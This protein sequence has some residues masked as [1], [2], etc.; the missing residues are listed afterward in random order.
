M[1][2]ESN[3]EL[4]FNSGMTEQKTAFITGQIENF[5]RNGDCTEFGANYLYSEG[6]GDDTTALASGSFIIDN[7]TEIQALYDQIKADLPATLP[8]DVID[9][10]L[11][12]RTKMY[13]AFRVKMVETFLPLNPGLTI[14]DINIVS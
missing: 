9:E 12:E 10:P 14:A 7:E 13:L 3:I 5:S 2:L 6:L 4:N 8:A 1:H 11:Q